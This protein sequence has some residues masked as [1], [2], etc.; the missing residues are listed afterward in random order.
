MEEFKYFGKTLKCQNSIHEE[1]MSTLK[2]GN[3]CYHSVQR[4][5]P[6]LR[7]FEKRALKR[8]FGPKRDEVKG[9]WRRLHNEEL[10]D[11]YCSSN[12]IRAIKSRRIRWAGHV[13]CMGRGAVHTGFLV[14]KSEGKRPPGRVRRRCEMISTWIFRKWDEWAL[15]GFMWP[16]IGTGGVLL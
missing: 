2:L 9:E 5:G 11:L 3:A 8:I 6:R 7:V 15:T 14:G 1:I 13:A 10:H 12:I 4:E 16:T